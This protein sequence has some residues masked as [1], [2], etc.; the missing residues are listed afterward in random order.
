MGFAE[1]HSSSVHDQESDLAKD[2]GKVVE[3]RNGRLFLDYDSNFV[4]AQHSG[5]IRFSEHQLRSWCELLENRISWL[6]QRGIQHYFLVAPNPHSVYMEE[7]PPGFGEGE[8]RP[9]L[10]L[11]R[12]LESESS[13][14]KVIYPIEELIS[15]KHRNIY[16]RTETHWS[17]LGAFI[18]YKR[19]IEEVRATAQVPTLSEEDLELWELDLVGDLGEKL[20]PPQ[21]SVRLYADVRS[22]KAAV[23]SDNLIHNHGRRVEYRSK[24]A[25]RVTCLVYGDSYS[26]RL[27]PFLAESFE[28]LV[29]A[30]VP[31][32]DRNLFEREKPNVAICVM[33]ERFL[34][35]VPNDVGA[36]ALNELVAEK[37][38]HGATLEPYEW[39][40]TRVRD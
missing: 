11:L 35:S 10:Q 37:Q 7:L 9:I 22:P 38:A 28:R 27:L 1:P 12:Y 25:S 3:G 5:Q 4:K 16:P 15:Q 36:R 21:S 20:D 23:V 31:T 26:Y 13:R 8:R 39:K 17:E 30:H 40:A 29:F 18:A 19:L 6:E 24:G 2:D 14:G 34:I 32:L 33:A